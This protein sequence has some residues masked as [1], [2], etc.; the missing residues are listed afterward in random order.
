LTSVLSIL[1]NFF[2]DIFHQKDLLQKYLTEPHTET[3]LLHVTNP[4]K[5]LA[6]YLYTS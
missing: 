4:E 1:S 2:R 5:T 3:R 6:K